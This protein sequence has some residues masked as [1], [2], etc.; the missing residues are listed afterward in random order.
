MNLFI[1]SPAYFTQEQ[2][3]ID[4]IYNLCKAISCNINILLYTSSLDTI[5]ITPITAPV[6][7]GFKETKFISLAYRM[8]DISLYSDYDNFCKADITTKKKIIVEN[9]LRSLYV[10][11]KE[12]KNDFDYEQIEKDIKSIFCSGI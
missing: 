11:K 12:L 9:I 6:S 4:E 3:V 8:A 1:N 7:S 2:G 5:G 10:I